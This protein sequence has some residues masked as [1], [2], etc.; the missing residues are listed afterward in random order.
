MTR[1]EF[2][3]HRLSAILYE[4]WTPEQVDTIARTACAAVD[5]FHR[6][7]LMQALSTIAVRRDHTVTEAMAYRDGIEDTLDTWIEWEEDFTE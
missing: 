1:E 2:V 3:A 7:R 5:E 4:A 6:N